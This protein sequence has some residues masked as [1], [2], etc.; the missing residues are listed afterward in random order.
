MD[1]KETQELARGL[2]DLTDVPLAELLSAPNETV[3]A[4][5]LRRVVAAVD[6]PHTSAVSA[7]NSAV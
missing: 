7:F 2:V 1:V 3:L 6:Q 5:S 4:H